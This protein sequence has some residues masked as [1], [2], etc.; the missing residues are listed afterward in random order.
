[1]TMDELMASSFSKPM[2]FRRGDSVEGKII[3]KNDNEASVDIGAKAEAV[4]NKHEFSAEE[5]EKLKA[6]DNI[7]AYVAVSE[8]DLGQIVLSSD[9]QPSK[10]A[11]GSPAQFK[12]W[13]KF[14]QALRQKT[15]LNGRVTE[16]NKGGLMVEIDGVRG[17]V[18]SSQVSLGSMGEGGKSEGLAGL[19]GQTL[20]LTVI[21]V[22]PSANRL[23]FSARTQVNEKLKEK[24]ASF[25]SG[26]KVKGKIAAI[27]P[28]GLV[29]DLDGV[30][31]VVYTQEV[32]WEG[33]ED[34]NKKF[35][36]GEEVEAVVTGT[37]ENLGRVNLSIR[38]LS[39]DPF[40]KV[41]ESFEIDDVI[42]G[43]V[44][45]VSSNGVIVALKDSVEGFIPAASIEIGAD[46]QV[47]QTS[48]FLV[49]GIDKAKRRINLAPFLTSTK[50]LLYR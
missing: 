20:P 12:K 14:T 37:D 18:P 3:E 44:T 47:G 19:V 13:Q 46:Y 27:A 25:K 21:E 48:N 11:M 8:N 7:K 17:F 23:V 30:E 35:D 41:A 32:S 36:S 31:G 5:W 6:G 50:G 33:V 42:G 24:L 4:I 45:E 1:M 40:V 2:N 9:L 15:T 10:V 49:A 16:V 43:T 34:L 38:Q 26:E 22:D 29:I 28:F 39:E